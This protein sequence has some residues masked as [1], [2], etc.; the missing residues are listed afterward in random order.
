M[1]RSVDLKD[2]MLHDPVKV[3]VDDDVFEAIHLILIHKISGVCVVD[4]DDQ[5]AGVLSEMDCLNAILSAV[6]NEAMYAGPVK[7]FMTTEVISVRKSDNI[8]DVASDMLRQKQRRR[9]V[10]DDDGKLVGQVSCR[11]ILRAVKEFT[12]S[13]DPSEH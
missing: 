8:V 10:I 9:P 11:Q 4:D 3:R 12:G 13:I 7:Q 6:Y 1:L 2:Y 5:L